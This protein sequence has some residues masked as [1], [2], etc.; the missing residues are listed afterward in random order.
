MVPPQHVSYRLLVELAKVAPTDNAVEYVEKRLV[1]YRAVRVI[2]DEVRKRISYALNWAKEFSLPE[3]PI[4]LNQKEKIAVLQFGSKL[5]AL[6][7]PQEI[8]ALVFDTAR[9]NGFEP[10]DYF[11]VL[12]TSLLGV[13]KGPRLGSYILDIGPEDRRKA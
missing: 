5:A 13:E 7:G 4:E 6:R 8:Q 2:D 11:K 10:S 1:I 9:S 3:T 12:Y